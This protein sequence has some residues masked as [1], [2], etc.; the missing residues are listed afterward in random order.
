MRYFEIVCPHYQVIEQENIEIEP[1]GA[2]PDRAF[3]TAG[4]FFKTLQEKEQ[5]TRI[6]PGFDPDNCIHEPV[7]IR[8][9]DRLGQIEPGASGK[10]YFVMS[11][12]SPDSVPAIGKPISQIRSD[13]DKG[14]A[15]HPFAAA[16]TPE[17]PVQQ[18]ASAC[19][20]PR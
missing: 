13:A 7:L 12:N 16:D 18:R 14:S 15:A 9:V 4:G 3:F 17:A 10:I 1:A 6:E 8:E 11:G 20:S 2:A 19:N 5:R